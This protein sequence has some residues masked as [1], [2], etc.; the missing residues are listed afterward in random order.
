VLGKG[1]KLSTISCAGQI[2]KHYQ[3]FQFPLKY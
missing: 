3:I 1:K 2:A